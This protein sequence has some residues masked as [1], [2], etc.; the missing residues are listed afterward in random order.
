VRRLV[1]LHGGTVRAKSQGLGKGSTFIVRLPRMREAPA[2][3]Y[4]SASQTSMLCGRK[5]LVVDDNV[6]AAEMLATLLETEGHLPSIA[7][8]GVG[9]MEMFESVRPDI[10]LLDLGLPDLDGLE[11]ARHLRARSSDVMLVAVT[12]YGDESMRARSRESG[13][14]HHLLKPVDL[15][16][17]RSLLLTR[18]KHAAH[19]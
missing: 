2:T 8:D 12:G 3:T 13:F 7:Y 5:I 9:A 10:V 18:R 6:D 19:E 4:A 15:D 16:A 11:V 14:D 1:E 17:L